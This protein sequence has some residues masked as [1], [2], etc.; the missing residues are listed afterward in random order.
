MN[1]GERS[2]GSINELGSFHRDDNKHEEKGFF[3]CGV[4][5]RLGNDGDEERVPGRGGVDVT[6]GHGSG[7]AKK[8]GEGE[9]TRHRHSGCTVLYLRYIQ[10]CVEYGVLRRVRST[11]Y[12]TIPPL[13]NRTSFT[14]EKRYD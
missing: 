12:C 4:G 7:P 11:P 10:N 5:R 6:D 8:E 14:C 1:L 9:R 2:W 13:N 3:Q